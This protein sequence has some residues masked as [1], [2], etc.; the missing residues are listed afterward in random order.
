MDLF[1]AVKEAVSTRQAAEHYGLTVS[2][3]GMALCPF[4]GD[5]NP[6]LKVDRRFH[7]F[8][9]LFVVQT[10]IHIFLDDRQPKLNGFQPLTIG[11]TLRV[12]LNFR[13]QFLN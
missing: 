11:L 1:Q 5:K 9:L 7:C 8:N 12:N 4:H 2:R 13:D 10:D 6:S 3:N